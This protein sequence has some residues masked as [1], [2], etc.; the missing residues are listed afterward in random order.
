[1]LYRFTK[2][3]QCPDPS[4]APPKPTKTTT[5]TSTTTTSTTKITT[6]TTTMTTTPRPARPRTPRPLRRTR[7]TK[8]PP[9]TTTPKPTSTTISD[10][11]L[12]ALADSR[13]SDTISDVSTSHSPPLENAQKDVRTAIAGKFPERP[14]KYIV[15]DWIWYV[16]DTD[17]AFL[18]SIFNA[19]V[20]F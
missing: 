19:Y 1:M 6:I 7:L 20:I 4:K 3:V 17:N 9:S 5:S 10:Y 15:T 12:F 8:A 2:G 18:V 14:S 16:F 11:D 13:L